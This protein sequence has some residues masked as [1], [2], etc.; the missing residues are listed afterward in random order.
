MGLMRTFPIPALFGAAATAA[1]LA[2][3]PAVV[4]SGHALAQTISPQ[5]TLEINV[6]SGELLRLPRPA[7]KVFIADPAI[8]DF[9]AASSSSLLIFGRKAG[10]TTLY[11]LGSKDGVILSRRIVV[12]HDVGQLQGIVDS[13][14]PNSN[15][16][17][18]STPAGIV[19]SGQVETAQE[20]GHAE[21]LALGFVDKDG[22]IINQLEVTSPTQVNI[23][24]RI[25]E[26][27]REVTRRFGFNWEGAFSIGSSLVGIGTGR[28]ILNGGL[29][30]IR[31]ATITGT[32]GGSLFGLF[33]GGGDSV[34]GMIDALAQENLITIL[35]EPNL[36]ALSGETA[37]FIAGG[38]FPIPVAQDADQIT[39]EFKKFGVVL[40]FTPTVLS[41]NRI[42]MRIRPEVSELTD[43]G[44][45][46]QGG[47]VI[48]AITL[49]R[50]ETTIE[51][52]SGQSF[53]L[54]GLLQDETRQNISKFPGLGDIPV[55]GSLF[56]S[57]SFQRNET[58]LVIIA[59][60]YIVQPVSKGQLA[61]PIA[62]FQPPTDL[63]R[64]LSG[65]LARVSGQ[66]P[67]DLARP[68]GLR[69]VGD[70]GF[71]Y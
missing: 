11:A 20:A 30:F 67:S 62:G 49:R 41:P 39:I 34:G 31:D 26:V 35:A 22:S 8:A 57:E 40:D 66:V 48:P 53:A 61:D 45:I 71:F 51:L 63:E 15:I 5:S 44:A 52:G 29:P 55:L 2:I 4:G 38:E 36:T 33:E 7:S 58:E 27:S 69:L 65:K 19:L 56:Q 9:Q 32:G 14:L 21:R 68:G 3:S 42:S 1:L 17:V 18:R 64:I 6:N 24:V 70:A 25:V 12:R 13:E 43:E 60:A 10:Q 54:A 47:I 16:N 37:S 50:T 59:T 46:T 23:R 28:D